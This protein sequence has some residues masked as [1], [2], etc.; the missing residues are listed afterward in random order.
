MILKGA[1]PSAPGDREGRAPQGE[2][3]G[4]AD[5]R[6]AKA[7]FALVLLTDSRAGC[8]FSRRAQQRHQRSTSDWALTGG[9]SFAIIFIAR[10]T[11]KV[12]SHHCPAVAGN[13]RLRSGATH[14]AGAVS[15]EP[16]SVV[17]SAAAQRISAS[18]IASLTARPDCRLGEEAYCRYPCAAARNA[19]RRKRRQ[20]AKHSLPEVFSKITTVASTK[21]D[22][23][24]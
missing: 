24:T 17:D 6:G 4:A 11:M 9:S 13:A 7:G 20:H 23:N 5:C 2:G 15:L 8:L 10:K 14:S 3:C 18:F 12:R 19:A 16:R 21:H 22:G 1:G